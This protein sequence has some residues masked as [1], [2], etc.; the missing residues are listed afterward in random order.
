M[1][2]KNRK[3][4]EIHTKELAFLAGRCFGKLST[5]Y[6]NELLRRA[7]KQPKSKDEGR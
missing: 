5:M 3:L 4:K 6:Y 2:K 7:I 1:V